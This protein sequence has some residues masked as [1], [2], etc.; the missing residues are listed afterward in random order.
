VI[1]VTFADGASVVKCE[2]VINTEQNKKIGQMKEKMKAV[3]NARSN[4]V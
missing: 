3:I 1:K 2:E 4:Q